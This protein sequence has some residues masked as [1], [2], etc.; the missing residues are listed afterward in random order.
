MGIIYD[1]LL[2]IKYDQ[3]VARFRTLVVSTCVFRKRFLQKLLIKSILKGKVSSS[4]FAANS[5]S[6]KSAKVKF[7][8]IFDET[9]GLKTCF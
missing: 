5:V 6:V 1:S 9:D 7:W 3:N 2:T 4:S 8:K